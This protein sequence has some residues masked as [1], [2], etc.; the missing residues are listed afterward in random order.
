MK[1]DKIRPHLADY[2]VGGLRGRA[3]RRVTLHL[4]QCP[5]CRAELTA[6]ENTGSLVSRLGLD[7]SPLGTWNSIRQRITAPAH[8]RG[9]WARGWAL[10]SVA[11]ALLLVALIT[12]APRYQ[13]DQPET[14]PLVHPEQEEMQAGLEGHLA[15][16]WS[17]PLAD[18]AAVG[19]RLDAM[20]DDS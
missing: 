16:V 19:L 13:P 10:A 7:S 8:P 3:H 6:L 5:D 11:L 9:D 4:Q 17:A 18:A 2:S 14:V 20:E 12:F 15:A 1:C